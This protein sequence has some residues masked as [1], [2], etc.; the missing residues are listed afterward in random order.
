MCMNVKYTKQ[1]LEEIVKDC[2]SISEVLRKLNL[3]E[4][5]GSHSHLS[6]QIKKFNIDTAHFIGRS[7]NLNKKSLNR[8]SCS[9]ILILK[10]NGNREKSWRL[11]RAM[12][13]SGVKY[14]CVECG[15]TD[16]WNEKPITLQVDHLNGNFLDNRIDN[17]RFLCPNCHSQTEGYNGSKGLTDLLDVNRY[18]RDYRLRSKNNL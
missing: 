17:L 11:R 3:K 14:L 15:I 16:N 5:G 4:S 13:E 6:K 9:Q 10:D 12:I 8:K 18:H 1:K 7:H 2:K